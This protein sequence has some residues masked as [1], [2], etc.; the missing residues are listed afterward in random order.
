MSVKADAILEE[1][2]AKAANRAAAMVERATS[3][4]KPAKKKA[5]TKKKA[6]AKKKNA[7]TN[8]TVAFRASVDRFEDPGFIDQPFIVREIGVSEPDSPR[9]SDEF[10]PREDINGQ[11]CSLHIDCNQQQ[12]S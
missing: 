2:K 6:A 9:G 7:A 1:R 4:K 12:K 8:D 10:T 5:A 3:R 11:T